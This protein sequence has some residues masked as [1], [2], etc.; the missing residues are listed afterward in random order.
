MGIAWTLQRLRLIHLI[1]LGVIDI[2]KTINVCIRFLFPRGK[3]SWKTIYDC[4]QVIERFICYT[5]YEINYTLTHLH[6]EQIGLRNSECIYRNSFKINIEPEYFVLFVFIIYF[7][8]FLIYHILIELYC[9]NFFMS[10]RCCSISRLW[11]I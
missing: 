11:S 4:L 6:L 3:M 2:G 1:H 9:S 5:Y 10:T 7:K 8:G